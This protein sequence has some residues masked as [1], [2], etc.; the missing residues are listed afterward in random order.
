MRIVVLG[1]GE[2]DLVLALG[3]KPVGLAS[4]DATG[5]LSSYQED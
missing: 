1:I 5:G 4:A 3:I 2:L